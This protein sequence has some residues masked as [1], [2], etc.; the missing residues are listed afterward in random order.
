VDNCTQDL[1]EVGWEGEGGRIHL[2]QDR[3]QWWVLVATSINLQDP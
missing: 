1:Q 2:V 3:H